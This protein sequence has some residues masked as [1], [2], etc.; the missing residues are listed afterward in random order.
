VPS[1]N[2][3]GCQVHGTE[4]EE[5]KKKFTLCKFG[6]IWQTPGGRKEGKTG[7]GL[8]P[9]KGRANRKLERRTFWGGG[10]SF[11]GNGKT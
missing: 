3:R 8:L 1:V 2:Q 11:V 10:I 6:G 7:Q 4:E 9:G 5:K